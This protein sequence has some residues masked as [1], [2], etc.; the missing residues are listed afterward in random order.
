MA[1]NDGSVRVPGSDWPT[2]H[3]NR[4]DL[5]YIEDKLGK[6]ASLL[7]EEGEFA[8]NPRSRRAIRC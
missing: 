6:L 2:Q 7:G 4:R 1:L 5:L 8:A 3:Q